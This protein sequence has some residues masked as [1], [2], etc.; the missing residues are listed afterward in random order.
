MLA[1]LGGE[2]T[3]QYSTVLKLYAAINREEANKKAGIGTPDTCFLF[4]CVGTARLCVLFPDLC[5]MHQGHHGFFHVLY[6][7]PFLFGVEGVLAGKD[8]GAGQ[9]HEGQPRTVRAAP[10]AAPFGFHA[11]P[12]DGF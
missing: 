12:S 7:H 4:M 11:R 5:Q 1:A 8:V 6:R 9:P 2:H 3:H 10:D